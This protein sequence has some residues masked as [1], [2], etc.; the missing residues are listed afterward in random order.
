VP[1][2]VGL[3]CS[4]WQRKGISELIKKEFNIDIAVTTV[5]K[6]LKLWNFS[7]QK[8]L[9][10]SHG[11][12]PKKVA[13]WLEDFRGIHK[14]AIEEE[15][16]IYFADETEA[17]SENP[18]P[19]SYAP[20]GKTP[21]IMITGKRLALNI[22]SAVSTVGKMFYPASLESVRIDK[23]I[24]FMGKLITRSSRKIFLVVNNLKAHHSKKVTS[25]LEDHHDR[26]EI[27]YLPPYSPELNPDEYL[28]NILKGEQRKLPQPHEQEALNSNIH[29]ILKRVQNDSNIIKKIFDHDKV[30]Y[31]KVY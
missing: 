5:G 2:D 25:W 6:H 28:N 9:K 23:F 18:S 17:K 13:H 8:P 30:G 19:H 15:T 1:T 21:T 20:N 29:K 14:R 24:N 26:I 27:F 11:Q 7:K 4:T 12:E 3:N 22:I 31:A 10:K 16:D